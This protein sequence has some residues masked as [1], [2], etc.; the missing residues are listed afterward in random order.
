MFRVPKLISPYFFY[1]F[2]AENFS[3][4]YGIVGESLGIYCPKCFSGIFGIIWGKL[5]NLLPK[6]F[7]GFSK[8]KS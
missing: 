1:L 6:M 4:I 5:G 8:L 2:F 7:G 3:G